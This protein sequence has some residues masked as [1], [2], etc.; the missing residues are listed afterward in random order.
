MFSVIPKVMLEVFVYSLVAISR[1]FFLLFGPRGHVM[2]G[3][4]PRGVNHIF[5]LKDELKLGFSCNNLQNLGVSI[6]IP[7]TP[8]TGPLGPNSISPQLHQELGN[9]K[10]TNK[11]RS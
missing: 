1:V 7:E 8:S 2:L 6:D 3:I 10:K 4:S 11:V 5:G 9:E